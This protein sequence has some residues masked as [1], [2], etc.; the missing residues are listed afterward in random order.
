MAVSKKDMQTTVFLLEK[1]NNSS[2]INVYCRC[3]VLMLEQFIFCFRVLFFSNNFDRV[4]Y[5]P[6][7]PL[8]LFLS[9]YC[10][11]TSFTRS[12]L[13]AQTNSFQREYHSFSVF[14]FLSIL[15]FISVSVLYF[16]FCGS[17]LL[18]PFLF[19]YFF[20]YLFIL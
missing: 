11:I 15:L 10:K 3:H 2:L 18:C 19:I 6:E 8:S 13:H 20:V 12:F 7:H 9:L 1:T 5:H 17:F 4:P 14:L 16:P